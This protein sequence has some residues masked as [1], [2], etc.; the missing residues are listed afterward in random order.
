[1]RDFS[2]LSEKEVL[3]LAISL[4]E[5]DERIY[6]DFAEGLREN[7]PGSAEVFEGMRG[8]ESGHRRRLL[9][10]YRHKFGEDIPLIRRQDVK[11][12][13]QRQPVWLIQPL[14][15]Q[16]SATRRAPWKWKRAASTSAPPPALPTPASG[17]CSTTWPRWS[18][19]TRRAPT[20]WKK[21]SWGPAK[22]A[23]GRSSAPAL[24]AANRAAGT[25]RADGRF[26]LHAGRLSS[27]LPLPP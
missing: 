6:A 4:E 22:G 15:L 20:R 18:A 5:E 11:G 1:M 2:S 17:N 25:G 9:E 19:R 23:G 8:E 26:G 12:F 3:A 7:F 10:L 16:K 27:R 13:V 14:N 24:C 21:K